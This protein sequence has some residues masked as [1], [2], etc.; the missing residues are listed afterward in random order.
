MNP[1]TYTPTT[2]RQQWYID[3]V[4]N[5][6]LSTLER[7]LAVAHEQCPPIIAEELL[8]FGC[9]DKVVSDTAMAIVEHT[10]V[11]VAFERLLNECLLATPTTHL[12]MRLR[13]KAVKCQATPTYTLQ[14]IA[15][16]TDNR[17]LRNAVEREL[18]IRFAAEADFLED[19]EPY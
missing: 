10:C 3:A 1:D 11:P 4:F 9:E 15:S 16:M 7:C 19:E 5:T 12:E 18:S 14:V 6:A 8:V 17:V 2:E 13:L